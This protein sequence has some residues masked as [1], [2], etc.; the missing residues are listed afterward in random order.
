[1]YAV[2]RC[3]AIALPFVLAVAGC[4]NDPQVPA[5]SSTT[6]GASPYVR[7]DLGTLTCRAVD[8]MLAGAQDVGASTPLVISSISD[9][10][11]VESTSALGNIVADLI[12]TRRVQDGRLVTEMRLR[13]EVNS[14][15]GQVNFCCLEIGVR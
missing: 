1:M 14:V 9:V 15:K 11:N 7:G 5:I 10:Q 2:L 12:R 6:I 3:F 13:N 8:L 4:V